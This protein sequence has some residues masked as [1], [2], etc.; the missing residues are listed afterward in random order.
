MKT[1]IK[2]L[3][4]V[5]LAGII[6][7]SCATM[8]NYFLTKKP[9]ASIEKVS[10]KSISLHDIDLL[11]DIAVTN[12]YPLGISLKGIKMKFMVEKAQLFE[13]MTTKD[14]S[15]K[16]NGRSTQ[17]FAVNLKYAD[18]EKVVKNYAEKEY[19][20]CDITGEII[21]KLPKTGISGVPDSYSFPYKLAAQFPAIKPSVSLKNF[22]VDMP[23]L[24]QIADSLKRSGRQ[25]VSPEK[26]FG[27]LNGLISGKPAKLEDL[28][29]EDLDV[30][31]TISFDIEMQNK[32]KAKLNFNS[33]NYDFLVSDEQ[34][35]S[36]ESKSIKPAGQTTILSIKNQFS[37]KALSKSVIKIFRDKQGN[38]NFRGSTYIKLPD[39]ISREPV[40]LKFDEKGNFRI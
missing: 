16:A 30:K 7:S 15:V 12:P 38:F 36:G 10:I 9:E 39:S 33:I 29:P 8:E 5:I 21:I 4:I 27:L 18:I 19:L 13:T 34:L 31:I 28:A 35:I 32:T 2:T 20:N 25:T 23:S 22:K 24:E 40:L 37:S 6:L 17:Q 14:F 26:A 1:K 3:I 11:F